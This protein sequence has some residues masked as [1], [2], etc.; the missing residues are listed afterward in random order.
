MRYILVLCLLL[1]AMPVRAVPVTAG[2][3]RLDVVSD[4][5]VV[6]VGRAVLLITVRDASG[7]P[8]DGLKVSGLAQMPDMPMGEKE[9]PAK[10]QGQG[11]YRLAVQF[12]MEGAYQVTL[13]VGNVQATLTLH[14]GQKT[15]AAAA[16][17]TAPSAATVIPVAAGI[18]L[19]AAVLLALAR[20]WRP[21]PGVLGGWLLVLAMLGIS[22]WVVHRFRRPGSMTPIESQT[23]QMTLPAPPGTLPVSMAPVRRGTVV[24]TVRYSGQAVGYQEEA[25]AARIPGIVTWMPYYVGNRVAAGE[26]VA[27]LDLTQVGP[28]LASQQAAV[29][30]AEAGPQIAQADVDQIR[31]QLHEARADEASKTAAVGTARSEVSASEAAVRAAEADAAYKQEYARHSRLLAQQG[32]LSQEQADE[33]QT[34][35]TTAT[36]TA[37]QARSRLAAARMGLQGAEAELHAHHG[38]VMAMEASVRSMEAKVSQAR[39]EA[40]KAGAHLAAAQAE[41]SYAEVKSELDGMVTER[42]VSPGTLVTP[43]Q[44]LLKVAQIDPIRLQANVADTDLARIRTGAAVSVTDAAGHRAVGYVT[45][46]AP[47]VDPASR[48][49]LV[50]TVLSNPHAWFLPGAFVKLNIATGVTHNTL[51]VPARAVQGND[52]VWV[53]QPGPEPGQYQ[54]HPVTVTTGTSDGRKTAITSGLQE[55]EMVVTD[56]FDA[57]Q[58][59]LTVSRP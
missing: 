13:H 22:V 18:V 56:S 36:E 38:H 4:P 23:M 51:Y 35:A 1:S 40:E 20:G 8:L 16:T 7:K 41:R 21:S 44:A 19:L 33:D 9:A 12:A 10:P 57:M 31:A 6:P 59:G 24:G 53:G 58:D 49:G 46:V 34:A 47:A 37:V 30:A 5:A 32:A 17:A 26:I 27:R 28:A 55:G 45:S 3:Y 52:T 42:V 2:P 11:V 29:R 15:E 25:I 50:E 39:A 43:G 48:T 14:T 54:V